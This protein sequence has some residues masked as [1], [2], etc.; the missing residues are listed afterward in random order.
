MDES[1]GVSSISIHS[2]ISHA[3]SGRKRMADDDDDA[4][5]TGSQRYVYGCGA[6]NASHGPQERAHTDVGI[7][8]SG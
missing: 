5:A 7:G 6:D 8:I 3:T 4:G 2:S 1:D